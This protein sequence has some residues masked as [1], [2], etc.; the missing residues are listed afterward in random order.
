[1]G[2]SIDNIPGVHGVGEK[3]AVKL[4]S[5]YGSVPRLYDN[6]TLVT[7]KLRE[8]LAAGRKSALLSRELA[9]LNHEVPVAFDLEAF[10]RVEPDWT[11]PR[12]LWMEM[13][14]TRLLK[15]LPAPVATVSDTP[16]TVLSDRA[17]VAAWLAPVPAGAPLALDWA[18]EDRKSVV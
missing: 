3:T 15:E 10:R 13:E 6:L 16:V 5:Q 7:G 17:A 1:M 9:T 12:A 18:G 2:D 8:T 11:K 14:F 4:I